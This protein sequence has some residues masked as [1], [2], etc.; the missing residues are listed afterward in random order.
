M[1]VKKPFKVKGM[2]VVSP[3][4]SALW[5]KVKE[6][7]YQFNDKGQYSVDLICDPND[8]TVQA[9]INKL[10]TL[11]TTAYDE[12]VAG[13]GDLKI[14]PAK[15]KKIIKADVFK[16]EFDAEGEP[17]GNI[18]F[19]F[20]MNNVDDRDKGQDKISVIDGS[21]VKVDVDTMPEVGNGSTIR[22]KAYANPYYMPSTNTIGVSLLWEVMQLI[23]L[24]EYSGGDADGFD[25]EEDSFSAN[26]DDSADGFDD[27]EE[28]TDNGNF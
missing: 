8:P 19:K 24:V 5:C 9:Y 28:V 26:G 20:K 21:R 23:T 4:G 12:A 16:E 13:Q 6:P 7:D 14:Q 27:D 15:K 25:D 18:M 10:E 3:K 1:A 2:R 22:C 11:I 17:T